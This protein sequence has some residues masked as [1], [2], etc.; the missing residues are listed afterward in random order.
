[1]AQVKESGYQM[2]D[3]LMIERVKK[4]QEMKEKRMTLLEIKE[5]IK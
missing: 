4:I 2:Y 5:E 3:E 1:V